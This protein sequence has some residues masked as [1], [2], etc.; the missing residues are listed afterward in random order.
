MFHATMSPRISHTSPRPARTTFA[1]LILVATL[2]LAHVR[3]ASAQC[4]TTGDC[5]WPVGCGYAG[6]LTVP[7]IFAGPVGLRN[8]VLADRPVC[9]AVPGSGSFLINSFFD[10]FVEVSTD[11][12]ATWAPKAAAGI[13]GL[14]KLTPTTPPGSNP[15]GFDTEMLS[16]SLSGGTL[17]LGIM[18]RESPS[19]AS[20]GHTDDTS[21]GGGLFKIDSFFDI[22]VE[23]SLDGGATW[24]PSLQPSRLLLGTGNPTPVR[25]STWGAVKSIYR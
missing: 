5:L 13:P 14:M 12:G 24:V 15:R 20:V 18:V 21:L 8:L 1:F 4:T 2:M 19:R 22:F 3:L 9:T 16:L 25:V 23:M 11:G 6:S 17:P 7:V 10:V